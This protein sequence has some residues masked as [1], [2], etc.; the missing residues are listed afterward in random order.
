MRPRDCIECPEATEKYACGSSDLTRVSEQS[1][2]ARKQLRWGIEFDVN[3]FEEDDLYDVNTIGSLFKAWLRELPEE[4]FPQPIQD[5][6]SDRHGSEEKAPPALLAALSNLPPW[7]YYLLFA[8]TCHLSLLNAYSDKNKMSYHNLYVCFAPALKMNGDCFR[9]LVAD[10][11]NCW[12][13]CLTEKAALEQEYRILDATGV[14]KGLQPGLS[15]HEQMPLA[16]TENQPSSKIDTAIAPPPPTEF[17]SYHDGASHG[18][19]DQPSGSP[20]FQTQHHGNHDAQKEPSRGGEGSV[21]GRETGKASNNL[22]HSRSPS[23]L[24]ELSFP[25][26]ISPIFSSHP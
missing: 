11:R 21:R 24:P 15:V 16:P 25:Q 22:S 19:K 14:Q 2:T 10:W 20:S 13:G 12:K 6:L 1:F 23:Q 7:N 17:S 4:V 26:P 8:I 9:W 5:R 18:R 3:L